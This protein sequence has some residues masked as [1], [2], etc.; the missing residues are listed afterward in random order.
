MKNEK[1]NILA[2]EMLQ[3]KTKY[4]KKKRGENANQRKQCKMIEKK[5]VRVIQIWVQILLTFLSCGF[6]RS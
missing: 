1:Y 4:E 2:K 6:W 5:H 3:Q